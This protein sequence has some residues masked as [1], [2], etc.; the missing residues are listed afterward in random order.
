MTGRTSKKATV[1]QSQRYPDLRKNELFKST[2]DALIRNY[3]DSD[4]VLG[5]ASEEG[6]LERARQTVELSWYLY[7]HLAVWAQNQIVGYLWALKES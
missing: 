2:L 4:P 1:P 7:R 5:P 3:K 6:K